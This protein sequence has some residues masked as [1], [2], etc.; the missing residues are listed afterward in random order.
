MHAMYDM[1]DPN[2]SSVEQSYTRNSECEN[3]VL[4]QKL[5]NLSI[6]CFDVDTPSVR[7][8]DIIPLIDDQLTE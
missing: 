8:S 3:E 1:H 6:E 2:E 4:C 5:T 7:A